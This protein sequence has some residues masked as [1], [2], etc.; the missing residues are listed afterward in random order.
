MW[1]IAFLRRYCRS[2]TFYFRALC[3]TTIFNVL[4]LTC[5]FV[6]TSF[7]LL[8]EYFLDARRGF[9]ANFVT[10]CTFHMRRSISGCAVYDFLI[11]SP[12]HRESTKRYV[13]SCILLNFDS[14]E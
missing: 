2:L 6:R 5:E 7:C 12:S 9:T 4:K 11:R 1:S 13:A 10:L 14:R 3:A 8:C